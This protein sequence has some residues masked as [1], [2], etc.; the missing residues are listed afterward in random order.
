MSLAESSDC[1]GG[2][3]DA[4][5]AS[6][7][8]ATA[9]T[10]S[11]PASTSV[12]AIPRSTRS[13]AQSS[14]VL[15]IRSSS[16]HPTTRTCPLT[17]RARRNDG[18]SWFVRPR[19]VDRLPLPVPTS[20]PHLPTASLLSLLSFRRSLRRQREPG[21]APF[22]WSAPRRCAPSHWPPPPPPA[23]S[24]CGPTSWPATGPMSHSVGSRAE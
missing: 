15:P 12:T 9:P 4:L 23:S 13:V 17:S 11:A 19:L 16:T 22:S 18:A 6:L 7:A 24:A 21:R 10:G 3:I 20:C 5:A 2:L 14:V 1:G 8:V